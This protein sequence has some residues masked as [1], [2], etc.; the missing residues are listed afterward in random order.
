MA[1]IYQRQQY[2][3]EMGEAQ[4]S[5]DPWSLPCC[6]GRLQCSEAGTKSVKVGFAAASAIVLVAVRV[7]FISSTPWSA[8][9]TTLVGVCSQIAIQQVASKDIINLEKNFICDYNAELFLILPRLS[10]TTIL[11]SRD[12]LRPP[13]WSIWGSSGR[14]CGYISQS[15]FGY[16]SQAYR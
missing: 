9:V 4:T 13:E 3:E 14:S 11:H 1:A 8:A 10:L 16:R 6:E 12:H 5:Q 15:T 2:H 7:L